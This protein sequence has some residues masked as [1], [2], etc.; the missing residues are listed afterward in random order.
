MRGFFNPIQIALGA[1]LIF[2][3]GCNNA[4]TEQASAI[5]TGQWR[6]V[7]KLTESANLPFHFELIKEGDSYKA[8]VQ[9]ASERLEATEVKVENDSF[10]MRMPVFLSEFHGKISDGKKIEGLWSDFSR[11][12]DYHIPF[13]A[14]HGETSRFPLTSS[15]EPK[16]LDKTWEITFSPD[17]DEDRYPSIGNFIQ[18]G[19]KVTGTFLT[20]T[21]DYRYLEGV[22]DGN[23]LQLSAFD[24]SHAFLFTAQ[25]DENGELSGD[26]FSGTHWYEPWVGKA[27]PDASLRS[28]DELTYLKEGYEKIDFTFPNLEGKEVSLGDPIYQDKVVIVQILGSWCPNCMD[29]TKL[30]N[31]WYNQ[32]K[33]EGL[34]IVGVAFERSGDLETSIQ[35][36][37]RLKSHFNIGYEYVIA[38]TDYSTKE[39][40]EKFPMLNH[41]M[42]FPTSIFI[43]RKGKVRKIHTGFNG[44]GTGEPY[45]RF[46]DEYTLFIEQLLREGDV[47]NVALR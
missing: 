12:N 42:S 44:P 10:F 40:A 29:E 7:L 9:N 2:A 4:P 16:N 21:G 36:L 35:G 8:I 3:L 13:E 20:E 22:M 27:N 14:T 38:S 34:E 45:Q 1:I 17:S 31:K 26:F 43:D 23:M 30:F 24:G 25:L 11:G 39:A 19:K 6:T 47:G 15:E 18:D 5:Q 32:Y 28:P 37:E 33:E 41:V 46:V